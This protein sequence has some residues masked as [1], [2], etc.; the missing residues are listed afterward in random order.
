MEA[1]A[2]GHTSTWR[3]LLLLLNCILLTV[4]NCGG[5]LI[6][7]LY[8][9]KGG[10]RIWLS[11]FLQT[12]GF[13]LILIPLTVAYACRR[14]SA[15]S[16]KLVF[17]NRR[18]FLASIIIGLVTGGCNYFYSYGLAQLPVSTATLIVS[19]QLVFNAA[20]SFLLVKQRFTAHSVNAVVLLTVGAVVLGINSS[21]DRPVGVTGKEYA[22]GFAMAVGA[23][24]LGGFMLPLVELTYA[25]AR[26]AVTYT[27]VLEIQMMMCVFAAA[28][29]SV[30]MLINGDFQVCKHTHVFV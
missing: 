20:F 10:K 25:K 11:S 4:G 3:K 30:G 5:P 18:V 27:L 7:R 26:Q 12:A 6:M 21:G 28:F 23:A 29:C 14:R 17:M 2:G 22:L 19:T 1:E 9:I 16:T 13:P 15:S 24:A 8:F